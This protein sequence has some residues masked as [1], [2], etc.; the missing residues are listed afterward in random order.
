MCRGGA[1]GSLE[2]HRGRLPAR[3]QPVAAPRCGHP[4]CSHHPGRRAV[5]THRAD[6]LEQFCV[7]VWRWYTPGGCL[8]TAPGGRLQVGVWR[9][10]VGRWLAIG[11]CPGGGRS[12]TGRSTPAPCSASSDPTAPVSRHHP[13]APRRFSSPPPARALRAFR[14]SAAKRGR[15]QT[16]G[17]GESREGRDTDGPPLRRVPGWPKAKTPSQP[18]AY[19][20]R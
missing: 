19:P 20:Q 4:Q 10:L 3:D 14:T 17:V 8:A 11:G 18:P 5:G 12:S 2:I 15:V 16:R 6:S 9:R 13:H 1:S 7:G